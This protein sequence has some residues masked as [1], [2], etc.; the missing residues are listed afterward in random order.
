MARYY[1]NTATRHDDPVQRQMA[2]RQARWLLRH[3]PPGERI[4]FIEIGCGRG[5]L[6]KEIS[7]SS[8]CVTAVG[9]DPDTRAIAWAK[10]HLSCD[11]RPSLAEP[12]ALRSLFDT[13]HDGQTLVGMAHTLEHMIDPASLLNQLVACGEH[14]LFVEVPDGEH[15][16]PILELSTSPHDS[17]G[18]HLWSFTRATLERMLAD[19]G[20]AI[21]VSERTGD[22]RF[23]RQARAAMGARAKASQ[24]RETGDR[25]VT[26]WAA[27]TN[28]LV[29]PAMARI[30]AEIARALGTATTRLDLPSVRV[31][32]RCF[33]RKEE[34]Q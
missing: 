11:V 5:W 9:L 15:E 3:L 29:R 12:E 6:V 7:G 21:C 22:P 2:E 8:R 24:A 16:G 17:V 34:P 31:L 33:R 25:S 32:A 18:Q 30:R 20:Y 10:E 19:A 28:G 13:R 1:R 14:W 23:W 26:G 4:A 27:R